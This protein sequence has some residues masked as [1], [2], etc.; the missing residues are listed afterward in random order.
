MMSASILTS[1]ATVGTVLL[2]AALVAY[3]LLWA[4]SSLAGYFAGA[5]WLP[6]R[7][8]RVQ[9]WLHGERQ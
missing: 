6:K 5:T 1:A 7:L 3:R 8:Q 2:I 9:H 4:G